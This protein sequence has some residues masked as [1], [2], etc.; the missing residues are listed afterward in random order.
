MHVVAFR[1]LSR[2]GTERAPIAGQLG[3]RLPVRAHHHPLI[4]QRVPPQFAHVPLTGGLT[5]DRR[6]SLAPGDAVQR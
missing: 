5:S 1:H 2:A 3:T 6:T 4:E